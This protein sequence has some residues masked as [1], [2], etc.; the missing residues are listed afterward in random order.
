MYKTGK[1]I[2][3]KYEEIIQIKKNF[4]DFIL[5]ID[6]VCKKLEKFNNEFESH[7]KFNEAIFNFYK[8]NKKIIILLK[9]LILLTLI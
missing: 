1:E 4:K 7:L 2:K 3:R 5:L 6:E 8:E 9:P